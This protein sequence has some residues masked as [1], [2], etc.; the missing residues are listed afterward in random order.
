M[1]KQQFEQLLT[2]VNPGG[3]HARRAGAMIENLRERYGKSHI[4]VI[5]SQRN[6]TDHRDMIKN[7]IIKM[8]QGTWMAVCSGDA[9]LGNTLTAVADEEIKR[10]CG[11]VGVGALACGT[12]CDGIRS[13]L[14]GTKGWAPYEVFEQAHPTPFRTGVCTVTPKLMPP[15]FRLRYGLYAS[16]I[17]TPNGADYANSD[18]MRNSGVADWRRDLAIAR[19]TVAHMQQARTLRLHGHDAFTEQLSDLIV[20]NITHMAGRR[21]QNVAIDD[22]RGMHAYTVP[23]EMPTGEALRRFWRG[24]L[25]SHYYPK[26]FGMVIE[27]EVRMQCDGE[28]ALTRV[29]ELSADQRGMYSEEDQIV[30][31]AE[32]KL[33][34]QRSDTECYP[35]TTLPLAV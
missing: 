4:E 9:I 23:A 18:K 3:R 10:V 32:S 33:I 11:V 17:S 28:T 29:A 24:S 16:A 13:F 6:A 5:C 7:K 27:D 22:T 12:K 21:L 31:P 26:G 1:S 14:P 20:P 8:G 25:P 34:F 2:V 15:L 19:Y 35:L 30:I